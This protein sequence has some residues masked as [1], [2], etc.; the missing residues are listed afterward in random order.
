[1][2]LLALCLS[3]QAEE[4]FQRVNKSEITGEQR[5]LFEIEVNHES[6]KDE[7]TWLKSS[8]FR[9]F[10]R[11]V[12]GALTLTPRTTYIYVFQELFGFCNF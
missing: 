12:T 10:C 11:F 1:M 2:K 4:R 7:K 3:F 6:S 5:D 8:G 9:H